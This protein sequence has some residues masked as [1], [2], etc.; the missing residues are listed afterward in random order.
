MVKEQ[1]QSPWFI[2]F[3]KTLSEHVLGI[4]I[5]IRKAKRFQDGKCEPND[6]GPSKTGEQKV[7]NN[8]YF[9][10]KKKSASG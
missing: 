6:P 8:F 3:A 5:N 4:K 2:T 10:K 9:G 7:L 1:Q